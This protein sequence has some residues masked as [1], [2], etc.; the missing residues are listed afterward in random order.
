[1]HYSNY[2]SLCGNLLT[3]PE[4]RELSTGTPVANA[5]LAVVDRFLVNKG[6]DISEKTSTFN[7]AFYGDMA[8]KALKLNAHTNLWVE[9]S[10]ETRSTSPTANRHVTEIVVWRFA[11]VTAID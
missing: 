9:G 5:R 7:L 3:D 2:V 6:N 1:M 11:I 10:I 8:L 4:M